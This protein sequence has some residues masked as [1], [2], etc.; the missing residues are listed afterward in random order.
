MYGKTPLHY[1]MAKN[2]TEFVDLLVEYKADVNARD[3]VSNLPLN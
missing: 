1:A 3:R 2:T